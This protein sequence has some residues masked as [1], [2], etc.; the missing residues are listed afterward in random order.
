MPDCLEKEIQ[1][2][3]KVRKDNLTQ[4]LRNMSTNTALLSFI[5]ELLIS[6]EYKLNVSEKI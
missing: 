6:I 5:A 1:R 2:L 4:R 3:A